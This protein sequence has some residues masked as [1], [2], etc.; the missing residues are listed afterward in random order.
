MA[1]SVDVP[2]PTSFRGG[3]DYVGGVNQISPIDI[4]SVMEKRKAAALI[5]LAFAGERA[6]HTTSSIDAIILCRSVYRRGAGSSHGYSAVRQDRQRGGRES[7]EK[8]QQRRALLSR[9]RQPRSLPRQRHQLE[10]VL[11][12]TWWNLGSDLLLGDLRCVSP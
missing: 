10:S 5:A 12:R 8:G 11:L 3:G 2:L 1:Y 4:M 6:A 9:T 7:S